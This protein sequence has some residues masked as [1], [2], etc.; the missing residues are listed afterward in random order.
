MSPHRTSRR[1]FLKLSAIAGAGIFA[2]NILRADDSVTRQLNFAGI[3]VS[4]NSLFSIWSNG[5][6][7]V[8]IALAVFTIMPAINNAFEAASAV[9]AP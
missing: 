8:A 2:P 4:L 3:G 5:I 6:G 1:N 7:V 9:P